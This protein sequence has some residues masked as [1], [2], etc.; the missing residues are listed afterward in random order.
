MIRHDLYPVALTDEPETAADRLK[1]VLFVDGATHF[2]ADGGPHDLMHT[3]CRECVEV[4]ADMLTTGGLDSAP[5]VTI[6][7]ADDSGPHYCDNGCDDPIVQERK[8][9]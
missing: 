1:I 3:V 6:R 7:P 8:F 9:V 2:D 5:W 4:T